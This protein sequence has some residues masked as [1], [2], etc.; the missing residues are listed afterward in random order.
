MTTSR[1]RRRN[2]VRAGIFVLLSIAIGLAILFALTDAW[3]AF[4]Q[5]TNT[6]VV[7]YQVEDGVSSLSRGSQVRVGGLDMG[8][9]TSVDVIDAD[10]TS[11]RIDVHFD[12]PEDIALRDDARIE[13]G[14]SFIG[15]EAWLDITSLGSDGATMVDDGGRLVGT[16]DPGLL[17][18]VLGGDGGGLLATA[19]DLVD[20]VSTD[21]DDIIRPTLEDVRGITGDARE[22]RWPEWA[23]AVGRVL[24]T[25]ESTATNADGTVAD[26]RA[27]V[28][29]WQAY[30]DEVRPK[31][32]TAVDN[33]VA[34][35]DEVKIAAEDVD[36]I[37][38]NFTEASVDVKELVAE[39][40]ERGAPILDTAERVLG[41]AD[42]ALISVESLVDEVQRDY[43]AWATDFSEVMGNAALASQQVKLAGIEIRRSPWK[44]LYRPT[45]S[46]LDH[47][48]L[49][50]AAR[51]FALGVTDLKTTTRTT[52]R[53]LTEHAGLLQD[54]PAAMQRVRDNLLNSL[55]R[56]EQAQTQLFDILLESSP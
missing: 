32:T 24:A 9:V 10:T 56:Y 1:D 46:E 16:P 38:Q 40:K 14:A 55:G 13:I 19:S 43:P 21:Y 36:A 54:D 7:T 2:N 29:E 35:T 12:L 47:E 44:I 52:E 33:V 41:N 18:G 23:D 42:E 51:S 28:R 5:K 6:Y 11:P 25:I 17:A 34:A 15:A 26:A 4:T 20:R 22:N 31:V 8:K 48:L 53:L 3:S 50:E 37:A 49:Y 30:S 45:A 39:F 27:F